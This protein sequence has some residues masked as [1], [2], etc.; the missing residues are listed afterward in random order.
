MKLRRIA[1]G[2]VALIATA[3][4]V[5]GPTVAITS[6]AAQPAHGVTPDCDVNWCKG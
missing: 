2:V 6:Q 4:F 1:L 5:A 3:G